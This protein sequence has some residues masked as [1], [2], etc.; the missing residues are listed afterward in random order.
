[1]LGDR[2]VN[3]EAGS[4][5]ANILQLIILGIQDASKSALSSADCDYEKGSSHCRIAKATVL[6][7]QTCRLVFETDL[8]MLPG[9]RLK[10]QT[11]GVWLFGLLVKLGQST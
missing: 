8:S 5:V 2:A 4:M 3:F 6:G 11:A 10:P 1:M 7:A 9:M